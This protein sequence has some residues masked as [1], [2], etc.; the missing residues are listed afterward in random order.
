MRE[1]RMSVRIAGGPAEGAD[2]MVELVC[3]AEGSRLRVRITSPGYLAQANCQFPRAIR[4][5]GRR[6]RVPASD[7][8]LVVGGRN[9]YHV[10][11]KHI[12]CLDEPAG[13][14]KV[15]EDEGEASCAICLEGFKDTVFAPC[16]HFYC[17]APCAAAVRNCPICREPIASRLNKSQIE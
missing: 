15:Y 8:R 2:E 7:V 9:F 12:A 11:N 4:V 6:Y 10:G 5:V 16:G 3:V 14:A 1:K 17:C 13:V